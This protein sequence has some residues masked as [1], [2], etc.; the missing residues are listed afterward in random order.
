MHVLNRVEKGS[1]PILVCLI[2][3]ALLVPVFIFLNITD[4]INLGRLYRILHNLRAPL[5]AEALSEL[6]RLLIQGTGGFG[7]KFILRLKEG[8]R[9][10]TKFEDSFTVLV[11]GT[12]NLSGLCFEVIVAHRIPE[13]FELIRF[14]L[15]LLFWTH[16]AALRTLL[17]S[18]ILGLLLLG[19]EIVTTIKNDVA[20]SFRPEFSKRFEIIALGLLFL[21]QK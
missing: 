8:S 9:G 16:E 17:R 20:V 5:A 14:V 1:I 19:L 2:D 15:C 13:Y 6:L 4:I 12:H 7:C 10:C 3:F 21:R 18:K 11:K